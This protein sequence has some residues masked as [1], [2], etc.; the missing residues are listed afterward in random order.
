MSAGFTM[1]YGSIYDG[2]LMGQ[3]PAAPVFA[4]LL[5]L[6]DK[7]GNIDLRPEL[8]A[9]KTGWPIELLREGIEQL[10]QPDPQSRSKEK[11]GRRLQP[12]DPDRP[13][14]WQVVNHKFYRE[15]SRLAAK[16]ALYTE[17]G[18]DA[19][20]K[21]DKCA[22]ATDTTAAT[23]AA[24]DAPAPSESSIPPHRLTRIRNFLTAHKG[25]DFFDSIRAQLPNVTAKQCARIEGSREF[26]AWE[27]YESYSS[28]V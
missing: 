6:A 11:D 12:L 20:R 21:R 23:V 27:D 28:G 5:P 7:N 3:W 24:P 26:K 18:R 2:S 25:N 10:M 17:S 14:G 15:K 8:I 1:V 13:W 9:F 19:E 16:N 4:T 22:E